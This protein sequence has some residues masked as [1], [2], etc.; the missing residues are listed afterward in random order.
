MAANLSAPPRIF[1]TQ[2]RDLDFT[3]AEKFGELVFMTSNDFWNIKK[4]KHNEQLIDE[5]NKHVK[6]FDQ[7]HD[8]FLL[9]GSQLVTAAVF[10]L[11]GKYGY[12]RVPVL[13]WSNRDRMYE[14]VEI[15]INI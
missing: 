7:N 2:E 13:R 3:P 5:L 11:L 14:P 9:A 6:T 1:V 4:S 12:N 8:Y 10:L 15:E